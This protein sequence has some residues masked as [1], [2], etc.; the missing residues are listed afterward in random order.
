MNKD[1]LKDVFANRKKL[2]KTDEVRVITVPRYDELSVKNLYDKLKSDEELMVYM[3]TNL[4]KSW[5][6]DRSYFHNVLNTVR[7]EILPMAI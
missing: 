5:T 3:P 6:I 4:A 7:P 1:F 2:L